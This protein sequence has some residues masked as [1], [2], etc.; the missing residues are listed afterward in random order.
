MR[1]SMV[2][3]LPL[4][5]EVPGLS[6]A[7]ILNLGLHLKLRL[8]PTK[9]EHLT[10]PNSMGR[11]KSILNYLSQAKIISM[12]S[13][14]YFASESMEKGATILNTGQWQSFGETSFFPNVIWSLTFLPTHFVIQYRWCLKQAWPTVINHSNHCSYLLALIVVTTYGRKN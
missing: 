4:Q 8:K 12:D 9:V 10:A 3:C 7:R 5:S 6:V 1:R 2:L 11:L 13:L 14:A